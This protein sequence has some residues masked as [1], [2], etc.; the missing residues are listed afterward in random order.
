MSVK[1]SEQSQITFVSLKARTSESDPTPYFGVNEKKGDNW[2][3][4]QKFNSVDGHI[5]EISHDHYEYEGQTKFKC[6]MKLFDADGSVTQV[7][8][9]FNNLLYSILNS[10]R[11]VKLDL[12]DIQVWL[13]KEKEGGNGK[14]YPSAKVKNNGQDLSWQVDYTTLPRPE[15]VKVGNIT[16]QDD[17]KVVDYWK[18][19]IDEEIKPNLSAVKETSEYADDKK[20][21]TEIVD[22]PVNAPTDDLPF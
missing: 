4:T 11:G 2:E 21:P 13:G 16:V 20:L 8:T 18:K 14:R 7:E 1:N 10:M 12:I 15:K 6:K 17:S 19:V 9:G 22:T 3:I 5:R